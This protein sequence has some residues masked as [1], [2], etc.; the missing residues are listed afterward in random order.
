VRFN[1][2]VVIASPETNLPKEH[3]HVYLARKL[4]AKVIDNPESFSVEDLVNIFKIVKNRKRSMDILDQE[5]FP[6][7]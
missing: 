4:A 7:I 5:H 2:N 6:K 3:N 1:P